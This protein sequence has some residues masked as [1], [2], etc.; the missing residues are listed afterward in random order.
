MATAPFKYTDDEWAKISK[1]L[2][3][4]DDSAAVREALE[5]AGLQYRI[6]R[7]DEEIRDS[8]LQQKDRQELGKAA[9]RVFD[10]LEAMPAAEIGLRRHP[11][12]KRDLRRWL[13]LI[14]TCIEA[15]DDRLLKKRT[16]AEKLSK[17]W[18]VTRVLEVYR[19]K[20][21]RPIPK[22]GGNPDGRLARFLIDAANP[23]LKPDSINTGSAA[24]SLIS[25]MQDRR[26]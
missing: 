5:F 4:G 3:A 23:I 22:S 25:E 14:A 1:H 18:V 11:D 8:R 16:N 19:A 17:G 21:Q 6:L 12:A 10:L 20:L 13:N 24:R 26:A 15:D 9:R 7:T 2:G